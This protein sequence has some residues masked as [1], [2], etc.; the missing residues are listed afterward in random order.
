VVASVVVS[1]GED[2]ASRVVLL[3]SSGARANL[4]GGVALA[5]VT[6]RVRLPL[7]SRAGLAHCDCPPQE[8]PPVQSLFSF[9]RRVSRRW[10]VIG[11]VALSALAELFGNGGKDKASGAGR[12]AASFV[13]WPRLD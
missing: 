7:S 1:I 12:A 2:M 10:V 5:V 4:G 3:A 11:E 6:G 9:S 13:V 8:R